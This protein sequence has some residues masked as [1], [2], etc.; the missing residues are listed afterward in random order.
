M[1]NC[2]FS[3]AEIL[4]TLAIIGVVASLTIPVI[5]NNTQNQET[6][7]KVR[8]M[9]SSLYQI[10]EDLKREYGSLDNLP[11]GDYNDPQGAEAVMNIFAA[12]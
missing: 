1:K 4:V 10:T 9:Y 11:W 3:L 8:K 2:G 5:I 12:K 7:T 6:V